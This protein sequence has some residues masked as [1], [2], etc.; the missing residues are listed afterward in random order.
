MARSIFAMI[1]VTRTVYGPKDHRFCTLDRTDP[2]NKT[3]N[4]KYL[5]RCRNQ[6]NYVIYC[7]YCTL[8]SIVP[9]NDG[10]RQSEL[11]TGDFVCY[12]CFEKHYKHNL[13]TV[14]Y[15]CGKENCLEL[16][17]TSPII[18]LDER[19][20]INYQH[21]YQYARDINTEL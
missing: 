20:I 11:T 10:M 2:Y 5:D 12:R 7:P 8:D 19:K 6:C 13:D 17:I 3:G 9:V 21:V 4:Y 18:G 15:N 1:Q 14:I 16:S